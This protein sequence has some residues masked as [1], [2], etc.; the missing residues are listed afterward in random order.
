MLF[1]DLGLGVGAVPGTL[2]CLAAA[3]SIQHVAVFK[4]AHWY[5][6]RLLPLFDIFEACTPLPR[7]VR[8]RFIADSGYSSGLVR[9]G[10]AVLSCLSVENAI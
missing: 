7:F 9:F 3:C 10:L 8:H 6:Q 5:C 1:T 2:T 4:T